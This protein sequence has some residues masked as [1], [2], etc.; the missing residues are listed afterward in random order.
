[1]LSIV[2]RWKLGQNTEQLQSHIL[3]KVGVDAYYSNKHRLAAYWS[4]LFYYI[5]QA[6]QHLLKVMSYVFNFTFMY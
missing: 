4:C 2:N 3:F 5:R 1:M 6:A